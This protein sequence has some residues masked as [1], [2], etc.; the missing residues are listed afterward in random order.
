VTQPG[1]HGAE[2]RERLGVGAELLAVAG[3][4]APH[5]TQGV[6]GAPPLEL[7]DGDDV[8]EVEHVDLL[9]LRRRAVLRRHDVQRDV[10]HVGDG[11][12]ALADA[13]RLHD[14]DVGAPRLARLDHRRHV[15]G[16]L[17][18]GRPR[19]HRPEE[20]LRRVDRV[21]ADAVAQQGATGPAAGGI[22]G[23]DG[24]PD[25]VLL[26]EAEAEHQLVGE[27]RLARATGAGDAQDR[28]APGGGGRRQLGR[29]GAG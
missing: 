9:E 26:V 4:L 17:G 19:G 21:H 24:D 28:D 15:V 25:L 29:E 12:V 23:E 3:H 27:R 2:H 18:G 13:G 22:D 20:D 10:G 5:L 7:V 14:H 6:L 8:G 11:R 1:R 16:H